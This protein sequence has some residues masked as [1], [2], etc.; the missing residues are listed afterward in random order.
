MSG[1]VLPT[2]YQQMIHLSR[3]ARWVEEANRRETWGETV[4]RYV[5]FMCDVQCKGKI[6]KE[7]REELREA[8]VGLEVMPSM[9]CLMTAGKA[10]ETDNVAGFNCTG[11]VIDDMAAFAEMLYILM[12][13]AGV[14]FSVERQFICSLPSIAEHIRPSRTVIKVEDSRVGW[15]DALRE[16]VSMLYQGRQP[17]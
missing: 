4:D 8:V 14:G 16:L 6:P 10:L 9:R 2:L 12:C 15:A 13:G 3:Y 1:C 17:E 5:D 11:V 7:V